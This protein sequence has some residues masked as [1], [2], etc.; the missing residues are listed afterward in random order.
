MEQRVDAL[1]GPALVGLA[2]DFQALLGQARDV[3]A[4]LQSA[5]LFGEASAELEQAF[6]DS[7]SCQT[8]QADS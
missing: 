2:D 3:V 8:L 5:S 4:R 1:S 7:A 6:A